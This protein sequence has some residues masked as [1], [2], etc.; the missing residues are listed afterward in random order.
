MDN[1]SEKNVNNNANKHK[2]Q[3]LQKKLQTS[4]GNCKTTFQRVIILVTQNFYYRCQLLQTLLQSINPVLKMFSTD[5]ESNKE[6]IWQLLN[7][8]FTKLHSPP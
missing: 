4:H 7:Y 1:T 8:Q 2:Q 3:F 5:N 6:S